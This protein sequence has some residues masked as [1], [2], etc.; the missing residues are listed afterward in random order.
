MNTATRLRPPLDGSRVHFVAI[1]GVGMAALAELLLRLGYDVSG[2]DLKDSRAVRRLRDLGARIA[3][4]P[5]RAESAAGADHVVVSAAVPRGN[6]E[7]TMAQERDVEVISR[8]QLLGRIFACGRGVAV[9]GTHGKTTTSSMLGWALQ[10][11]GL[12]PSYI[13]GGD[14]NDV[15][16][17]AHLGLSDI[18][19]AEADEFQGSFLELTSELALV[20]NVDADHLDFYAGQD[21]IDDAFLT[22]LSQTARAVVCTDDP[23]VRRVRD[24]IGVPVVT[25]GTRDADVVV[26]GEA[27]GR[28]LVVGGRDAG[29]LRLHLPGSHNALNA[30]GV[31]AAAVE[32][33]ADPA[34]ILDGLA[35]F[36]GVNRRFSVRGV[37]AGVTVIDDYAHNPGKVAATLQAAREAYPGSRVV[38][39][40]Q[41]HLF[42]RTRTLATQFGPAF[43]LADVL[44]V[45]D[46]YGDREL[47][48]P[49][50]SGRLVSDA[51][52]ASGRQ[53]I[54]AFVPR[55]EEAAGV[56]AGL[57]Q[58]GDVVL[59]LGAGDVTLAAPRILE[60]LDTDAASRQT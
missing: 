8:A 32:L 24:R 15:G 25:Y 58:S 5:H 31:M 55:L 38:V 57:A 19:V 12:D 18:V 42:S 21:E 29:R 11:A 49:G 14:L 7:V 37:S 45:T 3:V 10:S 28:R 30:A 44:V 22:F 1:G 54:V 33:G 46:V 59:T 2:S 56:V 36:P 13:V 47:P 6:P 4:G 50:V 60:L 20:T 43:D 53:R 52:R 26:T 23:G 17:G 34:R 27:D 40:F 41:P 9:A 16:S 51:V 48:E 35:S 39:L